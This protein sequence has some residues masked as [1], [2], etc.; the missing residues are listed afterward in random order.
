MFSHLKAQFTKLIFDTL[1]FYFILSPTKESD[2]LYVIAGFKGEELDDM[3]KYDLATR[4]WT[5][6]TSVPRK[7][8]VFACATVKSDAIKFDGKRIRLVLNG[9][10]VDPSTKGHNGAGEFTNETYIFEG[11][12]WHK[13]ADSAVKPSNRGWHAGCFGFGDK[14]YIFGGN[15]EDNKRTNELW[16]LSF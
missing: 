13:L 15:L 12:K 8:S 5:Q 4:Q 7:L 1:K 10:E 9:G 2:C 16:S 3:Y 11:S 6:M 14:F